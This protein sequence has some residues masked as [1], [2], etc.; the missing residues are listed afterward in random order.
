MKALLDE[1]GFII[2]Y[3]L[4]G[5]LVDGIDLPDPEDITHFE[6][7]FTAYQVRDGAA[8]FD[9]AQNEALQIEA[10]KNEFR[11]RREKECFSIINRGQLWYEGVSIT[12]LLELRQWYKAWLNVTETMVV[13]EKPSWLE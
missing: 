7:H 9:S 12:Q 11:L 10:Q 1:K 3:A 2:S 4:V 6:E 8:A 5:D 13:P